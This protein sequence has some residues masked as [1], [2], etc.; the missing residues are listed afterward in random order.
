MSTPTHT[1]PACGASD[2][3]TDASD[4]ASDAHARALATTDLLRTVIDESP[5]IILLKNWD[6][7]FLLG[8]RALARLY[9]TTPDQLEG[10]DDGAFNPNAEQ[11]AFYLENVRQVM[12]GGQ[13]Q[14]VQEN[15][16]DVETGT[17]RYFHSIKKPL[18]GPDGEPRILVI[19]HD[20]TDLEL[21][22]REIEENERRYS[23]AMAAAGEGIWDWDLTTNLVRHN[24]KW[25]DLLGFDETE[26]EHPIGVFADL[27]HEDDRAEVTTALDAALQGGGEYH[28]EHRM[29]RR[30][31]RVIWVLDRGKVVE[32]DDDGR[33]TRM[34]GSISDITERMRVD[35]MKSEFVSTVSHELRSPLTAIRGALGLLEGGAAGDLPD[36]ARSMIA[37]AHQNSLRLN[38]LIDDLLDMES[39][40]DGRVRLDRVVQPLMPLVEQAIT[41]NQEYASQHGVTVTLVDRADGLAVDVDGLRL[42]QVLTN[43]LSNAAKYSPSGSTVTVS[44]ATVGTTVRVGV[45]DEGPGVP[46]EFRDRI[47]GKFSQA[48]ASDT[49]KRGGTG[50]GLAIAKE[51]MERMDGSI[52][53]ASGPGAGSTFYFDLPMR[54]S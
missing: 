33:P 14:V 41:D 24:A 52:S 45:R 21:A 22:H 53:F 40:A 9:G 28:H 1:C 36:S 8:N 3:D 35:Q 25:C 44:A 38:A 10:K 50:L 27:L 49:R 54:S 26:L 34:A 17:T 51:L 13:T 42:I 20:V 46:P 15:S 47:F 30:D 48:D 2:P 19:A 7:Q 39:L 5:D 4:V 6:G 11:V 29:R 18:I 16:T 37:V 23:Y 12:R 32:R 31:G 43:L